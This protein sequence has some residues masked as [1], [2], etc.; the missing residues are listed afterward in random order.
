MLFTRKIPSRLPLDLLQEERQV[1]SG[2]LYP[3]PPL[4]GDL[5][6]KKESRELMFVGGRRRGRKCGRC[7]TQ[8]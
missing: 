8:R 7:L 4:H 6:S 5:T 1:T 3:K 2:Q